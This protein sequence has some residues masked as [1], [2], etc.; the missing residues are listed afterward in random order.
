MITGLIIIEVVY[1]SSTASP[2][3]QI[4]VSKSKLVRGKAI[5][6]ILTLSLAREWQG[7]LGR[8]KDCICFMLP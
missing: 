3:L 8:H 4:P 6:V 5:Y 1:Y 7:N 2:F